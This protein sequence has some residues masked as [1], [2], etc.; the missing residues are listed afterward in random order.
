MKFHCKT[1]IILSAGSAFFSCQNSKVYCTVNGPIDSQNLNKECLLEIKWSQGT[2]LNHKHIDKYYSKI[3]EEILNEYI[4]KEYLPY[5]TLY[6]DF[7]CV[8]NDNL[9]FC[10]VNAALLALVDACIPIKCLF[11]GLSSFTDDNEVF[12]YDSKLVYQH[13][14]SHSDENKALNYLEEIKETILFE[15]NKKFKNKLIKN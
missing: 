3:L 15:I 5:K 13:S 2:I 11:F 12:V 10:A 1:K 4:V 6:L 7:Y 8:G 14:F 9:L